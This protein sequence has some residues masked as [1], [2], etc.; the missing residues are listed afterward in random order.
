[1]RGFVF[2]FFANGGQPPHEY[3]GLSLEILSVL[4]M[5]KLLACLR[6][7]GDTLLINSRVVVAASLKLVKPIKAE[8]AHA[9]RHVM[10]II[11]LIC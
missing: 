3:W 9:T 11:I 7:C 4:K 6:E 8:F 1:M 10:Q 2:K 5:N